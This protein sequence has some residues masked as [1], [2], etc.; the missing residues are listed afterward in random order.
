M[1]QAS[2]R[3]IIASLVTAL[4]LLSPASA[5]P[6]PPSPAGEW[7]FVSGKMRGGCILAGHLD[8]T[9]GRDGKLACIFTARWSCD[10]AA[11]K[12]VDTQQS[13]TAEQAGNDVVI[14]SRIDKVTR[15]DP[16]E[17]IDYMRAN[18]AADHFRVRINTAGD[19]MRGL[20]HSYG[21]AQVVFRRR[22]ELVG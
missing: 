13:C 21:Q 22:I 7:S 17:L 10:L 12:Q 2:S 5:D 8:M 11:M 16:P 18:Y 6:T 9:R 20:F 3:R 14:T 15:A 4:L 1:K 19:E